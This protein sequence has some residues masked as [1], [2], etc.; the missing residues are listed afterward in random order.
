[1]TTPEVAAARVL[2]CEVEAVPLLTETASLPRPVM[3]PDAYAVIRSEALPVSVVTELA[4]T[5]PEVL[6]SRVLRTEA[7][8]VV[9]ERVT[10]SSPRLLMPE[11]S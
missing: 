4:L 1:M 9:S 5:V 10:A 8:R 6:S 3:P 7:A 2:A 11:E